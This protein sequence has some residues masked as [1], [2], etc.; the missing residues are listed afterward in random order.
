MPPLLRRL[1]SCS[2]NFDESLAN[3]LNRNA[4][5]DSDLMEAVSEII[6]NVKANGDAALVEYSRRFD[7]VAATRLD[8]LAISQESLE[9]AWLRIT[10]TERED[11]SVAANRI[12]AYHEAQ[13]ETGFE[14]RDEQ[15]N[16]TVSELR[17]CNESEST[18]Q[19]GKL[20]THL[21]R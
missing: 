10:E 20:R 16:V 19:V 17:H 9:A 5:S 14:T 4:E 21:R 8:D 6:E 2:S 18:C 7:C 1:D 12:R 3:L 13:L 15:G 11:L